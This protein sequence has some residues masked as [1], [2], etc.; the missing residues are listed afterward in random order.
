MNYYYPSSI[1]LPGT[2]PGPDK[3]SV[4]GSG[5]GLAGPMPSSMPSF[6][7]Q[8]GM[9][10][11]APAG[12]LPPGSYGSAGSSLNGFGP[13]AGSP[14][15]GSAGLGSHRFT[16]S[17]Q[18]YAP[19]SSYAPATSFASSLASSPY[20]V[21]ISMYGNPHTASLSGHPSLASHN[22]A[23]LAASQSSGAPGLSGMR[24]A[25]PGMAPVSTTAAQPSLYHSSSPSMAAPSSM[26][27]YSGLGA[28]PSHQVGSSLY[29]SSIPGYHAGA[30]PLTSPLSGMSSYP[31]QMQPG[32]APY[33]LQRGYPGFSRQIP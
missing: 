28:P 33:G 19:P 7:Q 16:G 12:N 32:A 8:N 4:Y 2:Y 3:S 13:P 11:G 15:L 30:A 24:L 23:Y 20:S 27:G 10:P 18:A 29:A 17:P 25:S 31:A 22:G 9:P 5:A 6:Q 21:P 1:G 14:G 26:Y